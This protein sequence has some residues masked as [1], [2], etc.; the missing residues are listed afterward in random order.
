M[1]LYDV[2]VPTFK[3]TLTSLDAILAKAEAHAEEQGIDPQVLV[4]AR[5]APNMFP[6]SRQIQ[7]ASDSARRGAGLLAQ[8]EVPSIEDTESTFGELRAR[9]AQT[10]EFLDSL[11]KKQFKG[12][13]KRTVELALGDTT[14]KLP[15]TSF[16]MGFAMSNFSFHVVTAYN[17]LRHNGV[18]IGKMDYLGAP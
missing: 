3:R 5:L 8:V 16:L 17:I 9:I 4:N 6:L 14:L 18:D 1:S 2:S 12:A 11:K 7:I 10:I 15:A 13:K